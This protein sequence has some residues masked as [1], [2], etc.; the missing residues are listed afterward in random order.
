[1]SVIDEIKTR[2]DIVDM[3]SETVQLRRAGKNYTGF[4]P[5]H[6]NQRTPAFVVFPETGTW[7]CF[8]QCNEG[9]DVFRFVMKKENWD[10][11]EA[12]HFLAERAGVQ[13]KPLSD[14]Q[15]ITAEE[16]DL[17]RN[18]L[19]EA[20]IFF[21]NNLMNS[22]SG[23][24]ARNYIMEKRGLRQET[25]ES[26][27]LGF[28]PHSWNATL[29]YLLSKGYSIEDIRDA[30][31]VSER[32]SAS[33]QKD[34]NQAEAEHFYDRFRNRIM[35]PIRD[36]RG[37]MAGFGARI[38]DPDDIPKFLNSPQTSIFDKSHLALW[39]RPCKESNPPTRPGCNCRRIF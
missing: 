27:G 12:L 2:I 17:L 3:V 20:V 36:M 9:G 13:L 38:L 10:F 16:H 24:A 32:E 14:E 33:T 8:G 1:M 15:Q 4:C 37:R 11:S 18:I 22:S 34:P 23:K 28:A 25:L 29:S 35:I 19:E 5:F 30:G 7:R 31:M 6:P 21:H 26:F 39:S